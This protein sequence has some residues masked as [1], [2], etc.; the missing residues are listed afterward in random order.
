MVI[1]APCYPIV[2]PYWALTTFQGIWSTLFLEELIQSLPQPS[3]VI[4][5]STPIFY[6]GKLD[7]EDKELT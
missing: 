2:K 3:Q 4:S 1:A 6:M 7:R 5:M